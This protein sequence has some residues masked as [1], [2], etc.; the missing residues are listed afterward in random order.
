MKR[1]YKAKIYAPSG[2]SLLVCRQTI[3]MA[4]SGYTAYGS[5]PFAS[6]WQAPGDKKRKALDDLEEDNQSNTSNTPQEQV[7]VVYRILYQQYGPPAQHLHPF[8]QFTGWPRPLPNYIF[9][10]AD[11]DSHK[12][13]IK[14]VTTSWNDAVDCIT[15]VVEEWIADSEYRWVPDWHDGKECRIFRTAALAV[16]D[17]VGK[18]WLEGPFPLRLSSRNL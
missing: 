4:T 13:G 18:V 14:F 7:Y 16:G 5:T 6:G 9:T 17:M 11:L 15:D 12:A 8:L 10:Q 3:F 1:C 2:P